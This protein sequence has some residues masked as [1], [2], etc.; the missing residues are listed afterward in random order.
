MEMELFADDAKLFSEIESEAEDRFLFD[1][2]AF[3]PDGNRDRSLFDIALDISALN[4]PPCG[5]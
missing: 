4:G 5:S 1:V 3:V 2:L